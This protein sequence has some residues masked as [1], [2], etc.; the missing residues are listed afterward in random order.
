MI[1]TLE[2]LKEQFEKVFSLSILRIEQSNK[3][4]TILKLS[5]SNYSSTE[6]QQVQ[7][8]LTEKGLKAS[9]DA[10]LNMPTATMTIDNSLSEIYKI[11]E[12]PV[13]T[14]FLK[15]FVD[16]KLNVHCNIKLRT[17]GSLQLV[18]A[19]DYSEVMQHFYK[20]KEDFLNVQVYYTG[21]Q[22]FGTS[23]LITDSLAHLQQKL[24]PSAQIN[25][26]PGAT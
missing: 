16:K 6:F 17:D 14:E 2:E 12:I 1:F 8:N 3:G 10:S 21:P 5:R 13:E 20:L 25:F 9:L 7:I 11:L 18:T 22:M 19:T 24:Q 15:K 4:K 23:L 26:Q